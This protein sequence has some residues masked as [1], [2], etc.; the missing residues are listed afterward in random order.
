MKYRQY[1]KE[2]GLLKTGIHEIRVKTNE[3]SVESMHRLL[4]RL[5]RF[6]R[7]NKELVAFELFVRD[8]PEAWFADIRKECHAT[9]D[10]MNTSHPYFMK[11]TLRKL[12]RTV[13]T[14]ARYAGD[15]AIEAELLCILLEA[16]HQ[17]RLHEH[18]ADKIQKIVTDTQVRLQKIIAKLHD[19]LQYDFI[20]RL[21]NLSI[22]N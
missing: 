3:L 17:R 4:T 13:K 22:N 10:D 12:I 18:T 21:A 14:Y 19:D 20:R 5:M 9:L 11:K 16:F 7:E 2:Q 6:K 8:E 15:P 1:M